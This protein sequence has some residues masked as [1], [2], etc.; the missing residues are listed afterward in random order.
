MAEFRVTN[1]ERNAVLNEASVNKVS[2][3]R[4]TRSITGA[5]LKESKDWVENGCMMGFDLSGNQWVL[6]GDD[7]LP[8]LM[9]RLF[10]LTAEIALIH[11]K[12]ESMGV[13]KSE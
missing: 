10:E 1:S 3:I 12:L 7:T 11:N 8:D 9:S 5:G 6:H 2:A 13:S 4:L